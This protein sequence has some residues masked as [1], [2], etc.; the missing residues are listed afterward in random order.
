M[1]LPAPEIKK[2]ILEV[3]VDG[4]PECVMKEAVAQPIVSEDHQIEVS[5]N[6]RFVGTFSR[7]IPD[8]L[9]KTIEDIKDENAL[10]NEH[11]DRQEMMF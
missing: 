8:V 7:D 4:H 6:Q 3:E 1:C 10:I 5:H 11:L 2:V 9:L